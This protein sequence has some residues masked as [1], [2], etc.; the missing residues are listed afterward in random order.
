MRL[1]Q[2]SRANQQRIDTRQGPGHELPVTGHGTNANS[3]NGFAFPRVFARVN[4]ESIMPQSVSDG[5]LLN[6]QHA[7]L[8]EIDDG[9]ETGLASSASI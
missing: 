6:N 3:A 9:V 4:H 1:P 2:Q 5:A 8:M 7:A